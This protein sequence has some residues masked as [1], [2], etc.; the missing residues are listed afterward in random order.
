ML[1]NM[2]KIKILKLKTK[3]ISMTNIVKN[4]LRVLE[5]ISSLNCES[6]DKSNVGRKQKMSDSKVVV[7]SLTA[8]FMC[9][10]YMQEIKDKIKKN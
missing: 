4:Y 10:I 9:A 6:G 5:I 2:L 1:I 8:E 3:P 7:L